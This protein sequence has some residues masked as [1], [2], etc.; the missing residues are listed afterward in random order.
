MGEF[1]H[2]GSKQN[3]LGKTPSADLV[4]ELSSELQVTKETPPC[5]IWHTWEDSGVKVENAMLFASALRKAAVPFDLH[6]YQKGRHGIGL[7]DKE[8]F[9]NAHPW[10]RDLVFW[11][12]EQGW[13]RR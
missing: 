8:P 3:L 12:R 2:A 9:T 11:L 4:R 10:S 13:A 7:N 6:I 1:T 5:F